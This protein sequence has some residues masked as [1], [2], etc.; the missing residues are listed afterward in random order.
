MAEYEEIIELTDES[1]Q[2]FQFD[3]LL[4]FEFEG[5]KYIALLPLEDVAG[6]GEDEVMIMRV[7]TEGDEDTYLPI[8][9]EDYLDK[10]FNEFLELWE[11]YLD[12]EEDED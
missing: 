6:V 11:E 1:G 5:K 2:E 10:V 8:E 7:E 4:T 12:D 3:H 9:D